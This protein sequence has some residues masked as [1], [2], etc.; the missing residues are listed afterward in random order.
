MKAVLILSGGLDSTVLAYYAKQRLNIEEL[1]LVTF[2]YGQRHIKEIESAAKTA[3]ALGA[4]HKIIDISFIKEMLKGNSLTDNIDVPEGHYE[5]EQM[6]ITVVPNR[7]AVMLTL[8][9]TLA[10]TSNADVLLIGAH[11]GDHFIYPDCRPEFIDSLNTA[12]SLG[13]L[14][15]K[16]ESLCIKAA[17]INMSKTDIVYLGSSIGVP[18]ENTW[19]CYKGLENHCGKCGS[20][21]ERKEAFILNKITDPTIY[22]D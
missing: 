12:L 11:G 17:F 15:H 3:K 14:G 20:C 13:T 8:A 2:N 6:S 19:T 18:F 1:I 4:E 9:Y 7:N 5:E 21:V 10:C 16:N 22:Q